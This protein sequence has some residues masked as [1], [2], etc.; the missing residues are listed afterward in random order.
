MRREE[1]AASGPCDA[2][3]LA[4]CLRGVVD[5]LEHLDAGDESKEASSAGIASIGPTMSACAWA[6]LSSPTCSETYGAKSAA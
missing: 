6:A 4:D 3:E 1:N 5:V 2:M